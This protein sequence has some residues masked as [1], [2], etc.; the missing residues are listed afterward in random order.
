MTMIDLDKLDALAKNT[1][2]EYACFVCHRTM[3]FEGTRHFS[4][5]KICRGAVRAIRRVRIPEDDLLALITELRE[6]RQT[7]NLMEDRQ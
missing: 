6:L 7:R 4:G 1:A 2:T 3:Q 5:D